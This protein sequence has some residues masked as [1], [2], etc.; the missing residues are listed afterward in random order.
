M[1][2]SARAASP[3]AEAEAVER[4]RIMLFCGRIS[5]YISLFKLGVV[6]CSLPKHGIS[7]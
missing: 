7:L 4:D 3:A 2:L 5:L 6:L 1:A